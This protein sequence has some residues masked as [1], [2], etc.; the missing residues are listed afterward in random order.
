MQNSGS[1][2]KSMKNPILYSY[3]KNYLFVACKN[4]ADSAFWSH[5]KKRRLNFATTCIKSTYFITRYLLLIE[6]SQLFQF[7]V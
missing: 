1:L 4:T 7:F 5:L 2:K 3:L 6:I